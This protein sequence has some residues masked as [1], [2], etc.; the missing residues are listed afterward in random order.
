MLDLR[1]AR[2]AKGDASPAG[3]ASHLASEA[4]KSMAVK[5]TRQ[6]LGKQKIGLEQDH[7]HAVFNTDCFNHLQW[8]GGGRRP[9]L[10]TRT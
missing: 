4:S 5:K 2:D 10:G 1:K 7:K 3:E 6:R 9:T 8:G